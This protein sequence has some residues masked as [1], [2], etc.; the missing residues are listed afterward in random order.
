[1]RTISMGRPRVYPPRARKPGRRL[2]LLDLLRFAAALAVVAF[3]FTARPNRSFGIDVNEVFPDLGTLTVYGSLGVELFFIISGFVILASVWGRSTGEFVA[4]RVARLFPAYWCAVVLTAAMMLLFRPAVL[5][6]SL[7]LGDAIANLTMG[8]SA[9]GARNVDGVYWTLFMELKFYLLVALLALLGINRVR[10]ITFA[11]LWP[12][13]AGLAGQADSELLSGLLCGRYSI[14]FCTGMLLFLI[15]RDGHSLLLWLLVGMQWALA[16]QFAATSLK[17]GLERSAG[18]EMPAGTAMAVVT[19]CF[20][21]VGAATLTPLSRLSWRWM[22]FV[23]SLTYP[24]YLIHE[25][26]GWVV[27]SE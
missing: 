18:H 12:F 3:H 1:M 25:N 5:G 8:Q 2:G 11:S 26:W 19:L 13:M 20:V 6:N 22:T 9:V 24:L 17:A 27:I 14:F 16:M 7:T 10:V 21:L 4:S 23:G 15:Y